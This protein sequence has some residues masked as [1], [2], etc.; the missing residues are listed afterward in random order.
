M[1]AIINGKGKSLTTVAVKQKI[2][3]SITTGWI[4]RSWL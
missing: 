4:V 3:P 2:S 1:K